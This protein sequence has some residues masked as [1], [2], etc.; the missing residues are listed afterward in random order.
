[1]SE[2]SFDSQATESGPEIIPESST[3][4]CPPA[5]SLQMPFETD[6]QEAEALRGAI[7]FLFALITSYDELLAMGES[8]G[9]GDN[10]PH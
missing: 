2:Y 9:G 1:M 3:A 4:V 8:A 10:G 6:S 7:S 5:S